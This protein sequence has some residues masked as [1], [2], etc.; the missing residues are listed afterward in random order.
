MNTEFVDIFLLA[1]TRIT[2]SSSPDLSFPCEYLAVLYNQMHFGP[3]LLIWMRYF[4]PRRV[5]KL[6]SAPRVKRKCGEFA[7]ACDSP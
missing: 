2:D 5:Y 4:G 6:G 3:A 1:H 7:Y